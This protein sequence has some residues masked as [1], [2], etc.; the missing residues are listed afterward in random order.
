MWRGEN[1][2]TK[3]W[4]LCNAMQCDERLIKGKVFMFLNQVNVN[5]SKGAL[6]TMLINTSQSLNYVN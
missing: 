1:S 4:W 3:Y 6:T 2:V 5:P